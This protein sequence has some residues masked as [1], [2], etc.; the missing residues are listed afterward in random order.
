M[1]HCSVAGGEVTKS[2]GGS[3]PLSIVLDTAPMLE[4]TPPLVINCWLYAAP[5]EA[6]GRES[7]T[8]WSGGA[9]C[10][11]SNGAAVKRPVLM[12]STT[13]YCEYWLE[14]QVARWTNSAASC[15]VHQS[16]RLPLA[17]NWRPWSSK[18]WV[19]S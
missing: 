11:C 3:A 5:T 9:V 12:S 13:V 10:A 16:R 19:S 7:V 18:P 14:T 6:S 8:I 4:Q 2:P 1:D 15:L 17:S